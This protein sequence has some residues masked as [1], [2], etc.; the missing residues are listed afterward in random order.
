[1]AVVAGAEPRVVAGCIRARVTPSAG[2]VTVVQGGVTLSREPVTVPQGGV[3]LA[4][5]RVTV[6]WPT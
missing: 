5:A 2:R 6:V 3:T 4:S 1:M